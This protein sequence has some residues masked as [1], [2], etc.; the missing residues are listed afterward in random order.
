LALSSLAAGQQLG[1]FKEEVLTDSHDNTTGHTNTILSVFN[2]TN[3][4]DNT[5]YS[6]RDNTVDD[7]S[8]K[9]NEDAIKWVCN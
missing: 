6:C 4:R 8:G 1:P 2:K 5:L 7:G 9:E 3:S